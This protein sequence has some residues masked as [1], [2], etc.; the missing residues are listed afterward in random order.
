MLL[1]TL[2]FS[3]VNLCVKILADSQNQFPEIQNFPVHQLVL[4]RSAVSLVICIAV[5]KASKIPFFGHNHKWLLARGIFGVTSLTLFFFTLQH[6]PIAIAT[7][8]QYLSPVFTVI[9]AIFLNKEIV[10][11]VQWI[12]FAISLSGIIVIGNVNDGAISYDPIWLL[13]GI[14]SAIISGLA[15][16]SIIKCKDTDA[17]ITVVMYFPLLATPVMIVACFFYGFL[18]PK[19]FTEWFLLILIGVLTQFAQLSMTKAFNSDNTA[20]VT[21]VKYIGGIYAV[22][23]GFFVFDETVGLVASLG[24]VLIVLGVL[25]NTLIKRGNFHQSSKV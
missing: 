17:P 8:V 15:Y 2:C 19:S 20:R 12:Y 5:I 9:F 11:P 23:I 6:L 22:A 16:N 14:G 13:A 1:S 4:F 7:T 10:R 24:M 25:L 18:I 21:P 3:L